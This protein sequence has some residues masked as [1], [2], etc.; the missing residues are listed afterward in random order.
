MQRDICLLEKHGIRLKLSKMRGLSKHSHSLFGEAAGDRL[1]RSTVPHRVACAGPNHFKNENHGRERKLCR[2]VRING[3]ICR[4]SKGCGS[5]V[6]LPRL[7]NPE[8]FRFAFISLIYSKP[9]RQASITSPS[10]RLTVGVEG[11]FHPETRLPVRWRP[12]I[13]RSYA[14]VQP[15][16]QRIDIIDRDPEC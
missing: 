12:K 11:V 14:G 6:S 9:E 1:N 13:T 7:I 2:S 4:I 10:Q 5:L 8:W 16:D 3:L 15:G